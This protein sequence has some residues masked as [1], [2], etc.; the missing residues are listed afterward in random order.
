MGIISMPNLPQKRVRTVIL[1]S[2]APEALIENINR[3]GIDIITV[4]P[5]CDIP[6]PVA[7]HADMLINHLNKNRIIVYSSIFESISDKLQ[8]IGFEVIKGN[9]T[10]KTTYPFDIAYNALRI[11]RFIFCLK[12]YTERELLNYCETNEIKI[13]PVKQGYAKCSVCI[14]DEQSIITS[15]LGI[16]TQAEKKGIAALLIRSGYI[17]LPEYEYGFIGGCCC[18]L[19]KDIIGFT[20]DIKLHPDYVNIKEF[21]LYRG[22]KDAALCEGTLNDIGSIIPLIEE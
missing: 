13:V 11:G 5:C 22:I 8:S 14:V 20:G 17:N 4:D 6:S 19:S 16:A 7:S 18:K 15:D 9:L 1:S 10:L 2:Q 21:L 12:E 3:R